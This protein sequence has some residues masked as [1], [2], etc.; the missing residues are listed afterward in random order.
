MLAY[1]LT[2][3]ATSAMLA[4]YF[5]TG[6]LVGQGRV[7]HKVK[8]PA[9]EGPDDFNR[10]Y[11]AHVNTL[12]QLVLMLP[13]MWIFALTVTDRWAALLGLVWVV[14]RVAYVLGYKAAAEKRDVGFVISF[15]AFAVALIG[16]VIQLVRGML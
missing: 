12:E 1:H 2:A 4:T 6:A 10:I 15:A 9:V 11:R 5:W 7:R 3:L 16:G 14:G 8:A 13:A